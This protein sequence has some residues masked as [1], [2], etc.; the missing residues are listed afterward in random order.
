[1]A[2]RRGTA[3]IALLNLAALASAAPAS[4][5]EAAASAS[6]IREFV[7]EHCFDCHDDA[8]R[9]GKLSLESLSD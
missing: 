2:R 8:T 3:L 1:M 6:K 7:A 4:A 5:S 9:K